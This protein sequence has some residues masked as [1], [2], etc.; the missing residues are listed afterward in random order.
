MKQYYLQIWLAFRR[1]AFIFNN[2]IYAGFVNQLPNHI[3]C[4]KN[5]I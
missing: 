5:E 3:I 1:S 4:R 2:I